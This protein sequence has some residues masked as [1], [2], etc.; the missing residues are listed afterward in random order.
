MSDLLRGR[1]IDTSSPGARRSLVILVESAAHALDLAPSAPDLLAG[2]L[3]TLRVEGGGAQ[4]EAIHGR[5]VPGSFGAEGDAL[6]WR[7]PAES[8]S[9][10][11]TLWARQ[12]ILRAVREHFHDEG[13]L[14]I[15]APLLVKGACPDAHLE[16]LHAG[17]DAYLTTSTEYQIKRMIVGGFDK[18]FTLTQNFRGSDVGGRHNPEFTMLEW[19]RTYAS[20]EDIERDAEALVKRA[21]RAVHPDAKVLRWAGLEVSIDGPWERV[22]VRQALARH[23]GDQAAPDLSPASLRSEV[24]RLGLDVPASFLDDDALLVS[25]LIDA[26]QPRLGAP[27]PTFL[28]EWP[29]FMTSSAAI[30]EGAPALADR[31]ELLVAGLELSDGFP[32]LR[33]PDLQAR[34]FDRENARRR[35]EARDRVAL[36]ARY[37][38]ALREGIPPGAGMALGIDRLVM[39]LTGRE[40]IRDVLALAWDEL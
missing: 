32:S 20:L 9:R 14:E 28:C 15:Q 40:R 11:E 4:V 2:D 16:P 35:D 12:A 37:L 5:A 24:A 31:S 10:M 18:V 38:A 13:F 7:R 23:L 36:D 34:L 22:T 27:A 33:D 6:R 8:P 25:Y 19:A 3:G 26:M 39:I 29:A 17:G 21:F 1:V 30:L